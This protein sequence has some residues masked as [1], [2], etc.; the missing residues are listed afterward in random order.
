MKFK[1]A[2]QKIVDLKANEK[3]Q[4]EWVF[5]SAV[6]VLR[7]EQHTLARLSEEKSELHERLIDESANPTP[8]SQLMMV[9]SYMQHIDRQITRKSADVRVAERNVTVKQEQLVHK[10]LEEKIWFQARDKA[11]QTF[12]QLQLKKE[13]EEL[14]DLATT[15]FKLMS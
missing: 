4:A 2:F 1:Y 3:T 11:K 15:R 13:Q 6:G 10:T 14:D 12:V 9:Q 8:I 7:A 5:S